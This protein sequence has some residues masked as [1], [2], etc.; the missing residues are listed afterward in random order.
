[1]KYNTEGA[2]A[3]LKS[4]R[5]LIL[6]VDGV[7]T[8]GQVIYDDQGIETK[9]FNVK[10]G[11]GLRLLMHC[12]IEVC[13]ATGRCAPALRHRCQNLGITRIYDGL[14]HKS[15]ILDP[16]SRQSGLTR[17]QMGFMGDDLPDLGLMQQV[18][19]AVAVA[20]AA[21]EVKAAADAVTGQPGGMGA[22]R[23]LCEAILKAQGRWAPL[24]QTIK[25][26]RL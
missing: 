5:L 7:L 2:Q 4:V 13:I 14:R 26:E 20:D 25:D 17:T 24:V 22:V 3:S 18:G 23:E 16:L 11:L 6:D 12:G 9:I 21:P 15:Q 10:D 8:R 1:M 19:L